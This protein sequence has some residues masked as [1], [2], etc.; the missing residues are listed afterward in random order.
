LVYDSSAMNS[1]YP[2]NHE[3]FGGSTRVGGAG[4]VALSKVATVAAI[5]VAAVACSSTNTTPNPDASAPTGGSVSCDSAPALTKAEYCSSCTMA[6]N[7]TPNKCQPPRNVNA[8]CTFV[9]APSQEL[10][11]GTGLV[12]NSSSDPA[13]QL[14]CLDD[15]GVQGASKTITLKGHVRLFSGGNDSAGVKIEIYREGANG[16]LGELVG[17]PVSTTDDDTKNPPLVPKP[18]WL[19]K[20]PDGGCTFRAYEYAGVPTEVPLIVKTSDAAGGEQ[21]SALYDYN[22][23]FSNGAVQAGDVVAYEPAAVAGTDINTVASAAGG[24]TVKQEKG[25]LAGEVHDCGDVRVAGATVDTD[26]PHE[27]EMF[28]FGENESDPLPD[29][30]R[31]SLGTSKL[32]LFGTLN[33]PT[34]VPIRVSALG[35]RNKETVLLG[36][37]TIQTFPG[38]VT[39]ISFRGRRPWQK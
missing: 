36:T 28:Y 10:A 30:S 18:D 13:L 20:C 14:G 21:W 3:R 31:G 8:C 33:L 1:S 5:A 37:H 35:L 15:P 16:A 22:V 19:K 26:A 34:G 39:A 25:L 4:L 12:R 7:A 2:E 6:A 11:R 24:F 27:S 32:G 29:K 9:Q 23:Y 17:A 38:S